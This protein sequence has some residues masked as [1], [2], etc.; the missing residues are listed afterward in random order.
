VEVVII[1]DTIVILARGP[2]SRRDG[3][4]VYGS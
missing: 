1:A 3:R 2:M 4:S